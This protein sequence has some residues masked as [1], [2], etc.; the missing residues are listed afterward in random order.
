[1]FVVVAA[2]AVPLATLI[3]GSDSAAAPPGGTRGDDVLRGTSS[4][5]VI[6]GRGGNDRIFGLG[7]ADRLIGGQGDDALVGGRGTDDLIA[8]RGD[9]E[10][11]AGDGGRDRVYCGAGFDRVTSSDANDQLFNCELV[12][13]NLPPAS[14]S[15]VLVDEPWI[16]RGPVNLDLVKITMRTV[17]EDA[18]YLREDCS[19]YIGRI[20]VETW[21]LDG[22][23]V[24][25]PPPAAHDLVIDGGYIRC[26]DHPPEAHQDGIQVMGGERITFRRLEIECSSEPNAQLFISGAN[27]G[28]ADQRRLRSLLPGSR[29]GLDALHRRTRSDREPAT[30]RSARGASPRCGSSPEAG[31]AVNSRQHGAG[32]DEPALRERLAAPPGG[33]LGSR[34]AR[35]CRRHAPGQPAAGRCSI[36][37]RSTSTGRSS[38][39]PAR[40][41]SARNMAEASSWPFR[42][43]HQRRRLSTVAD[44]E[45]V[46]MAKFSSLRRMPPTRGAGARR[47]DRPADGVRRR[48]SGGDRD[49]GKRHARRHRRRRLRSM[50]GAATIISTASA[51]SD[52]ITGGAGTDTM[53]GGAGDDKLWA[54]D[55][56]SDTIACGTGNDQVSADPLD[57]IS[58]DCEQRSIANPGSRRRRRRRR[59]RHSAAAAAPRRRRRRSD[60][61]G[62][63]RRRRRPGTGGGGTGGGGGGGGGTGS[64]VL[65]DQAWTCTGPVNLNLVK[66]TIRTC[67]DR[68][69]LPA[70]ELHG[71]DRQDRG[72]DLDG[73][74][75][76]GQRARPCRPR[77]RHRGR[78]HPL[79]R[80]RPRTPGRYPGDGRDT[81]D[82]PQ[83]RGQLQLEPE[84]AAL[85]QHA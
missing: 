84:R 47:H 9:D 32:R 58:G 34:C 25:A 82:V 22:V 18:I 67:P 68:R 77:P 51:D 56:E 14:A 53:L 10:L 71:P 44:H 81:C 12:D 66:V 64:I 40:N 57:Q 65:V 24:N 6:D 35:G 42:V 30:P 45:H 54:R 83:S 27:G 48:S 79:L 37:S 41:P 60:G 61:G 76:Q 43:A 11:A 38:C 39:G 3:S 1:M 5:D 63:L 50:A 19:G 59:R 26:F 62:G 15:I 33:K 74:R 75:P 20:E 21:T 8:G 36:G 29:G 69:D 17:L 16:C 78:L 55:G 23:K 13:R 73:R 49:P 31:D 70:S 72:P 85:R 7:G 2:I 28:R 52:R 4:S 80:E 46:G